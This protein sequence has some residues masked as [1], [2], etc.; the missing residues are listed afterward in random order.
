MAFLRK[1][2]LAGALLAAPALLHAQRE[3]LPPDDYDFVMKQWPTAQISNTGIRYI[4]ETPGKG[5]LI[6][7]GDIVS[8]NYEG[9]FLTGK[10]FD[11]DKNRV[12]PFSFR[13]DRGIVIPGW[14]QILQ[15]MSQGAKWIVII[16]PELG[17]GR[18]GSPPRI[19]GNATLV[20]EIEVLAVQRN[21]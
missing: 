8:V 5:P 16:P 4:V 21:S 17:Y 1:A 6:A 7:P 18:K 12:K 14:D 9:R 11:A 10:V 20:F 19:P 13:V 15:L 2:A 3:K